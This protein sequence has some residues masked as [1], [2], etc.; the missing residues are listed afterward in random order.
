[1]QLHLDDVITTAEA[2]AMLGVTPARVQAMVG[3]GQLPLLRRVGRQF[4]FHRADVAALVAARKANPP[5]TGPATGSP[6]ALAAGRRGAD[7][8]RRLHR[9]RAEAAA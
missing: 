9:A 3:Q 4:L 8:L 7:V 2:A 1:V 6:A 5:R